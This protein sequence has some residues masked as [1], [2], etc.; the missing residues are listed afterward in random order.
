MQHYEDTLPCEQSHPDMHT[1]HDFWLHK[2]C[3]FYTSVVTL[4][5]S[6]EYTNIITYNII[7]RI[8]N[9]EYVQEGQR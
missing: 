2:S 6:V 1:A 9:V 5:L 4:F 8:G 3:Q 7:S